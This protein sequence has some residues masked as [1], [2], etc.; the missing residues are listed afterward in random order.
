MLYLSKS[1][2]KAKI[3]LITE[4]R[5]QIFRSLKSPCFE[6]EEKSNF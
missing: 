3:T 5:K 2:S 4:I 6:G 1:K